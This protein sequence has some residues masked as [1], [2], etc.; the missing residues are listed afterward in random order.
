MSK[1]QKN[2][3]FWGSYYQVVGYASLSMFVLI[4]YMLTNFLIIGVQKW[5]IDDV[6]IE[7]DYN[8]LPYLLALF[9]VGFIGF[10][11]LN[12]VNG[13]IREI[14]YTKFLHGLSDRYISHI[15]EI[16]LQEF[17]KKRIGQYVYHFS[18]DIRGL[19]EA[20]SREIPTAIQQVL[21][22]I[23]LM[24]VIGWNSLMM[25]ALILVFSL[26]YIALGKYFA[27]R[28]KKASALVQASKSDLLI[29]I[30]EGISSTREVIA[31]NRQKWEKKLYDQFFHKY[32]SAVMKEGKL[33]NRHLFWSDPTRWAAS[34]SILG[35]GGYLVFQGQLSIGWLVVIY[36]F[37]MELVQA[38]HYL[39]QLILKISGKMA[40]Y[41]RLKEVFL[42]KPTEKGIV[43]LDE[44]IVSLAL[45]DIS[46]RY[47]EMDNLVLHNLNLSVHKCQKI[48]L[49]GA[50]G[51]G[52]S[53]LLQLLTKDNEP[54]S[55]SI[56]VNRSISL[57]DITR[58][59]WVSKVNIVFQEPYL[60]QDTIS[61]NIRF[62]NDKA[63]KED[64]IEACKIARIHDFIQTLPQG[65]E[66]IIGERGIT[67]SGGQRQRIALARAI[68]KKPDVL[69]LDEAT[70]ALD[71]ET[72]RQVQDALDKAFEDKIMI[73]VAHRL[74][75]IQNADVI[76]V[77]DQGQIVESGTHDTLISMDGVYAKLYEVQRESV[78]LG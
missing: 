17:Q 9:A 51:G 18:Q 50:S 52:K 45:D 54:T 10:A 7:G 62:G 58:E 72:E 20:V 63:T 42:H 16:P 44:S 15:G 30:E 35:Y 69:I 31:F 70:S 71:L 73:V 6:F 43:T 28:M 68:L 22:I 76:Y 25:L 39:F 48:A 34:I 26:L 24:G 21:Y 19:S 5:I 8:M 33:E 23:L 36:Q 11:I 3:W 14:V 46:F 27:S 67:L 53:T 65:Y 78:V 29:H 64:I 61:T 38:M 4:I 13:V 56:V 75:T 66:T 40:F 12:P 55:G 41:E 32:F 74:S 59:S 49:V 1:Q 60:F 77:L 2:H 47:A 57:N 37:G